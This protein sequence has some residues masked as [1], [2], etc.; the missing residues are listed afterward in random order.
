MAHIAHAAH[1]D[2][3]FGRLGARVL[4]T[5]AWVANS[6]N[7]SPLRLDRAGS[8]FGCGG[9]L[10]SRVPESSGQ[11]RELAPVEAAGGDHEQRSL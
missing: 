8:V 6:R 4:W 5:P 3:G 11:C 9:G 1:I 2:L 10:S 7:Y